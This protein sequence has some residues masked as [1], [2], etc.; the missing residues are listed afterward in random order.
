LVSSGCFKALLA[1]HQSSVLADQGSVAEQKKG[2][3][4]M[5]VS[6]TTLGEIRVAADKNKGAWG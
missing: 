3:S 2:T 6:K 4:G 5:Q 1:S